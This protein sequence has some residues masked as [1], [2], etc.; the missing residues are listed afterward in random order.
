MRYEFS[1]IEKKW[2][3]RWEK[4]PFF[5]TKNDKS[6]KKF[7]C[8]DMFPYPSGSGLHVGHWK[9]YVFSDVYARIKLL[10]GY[11]VL[12]PM[13]WDAFG[14]PAENDAIKKG[15]H[16]RDGTSRN[17][18]VFKGQLK[19]IGATYDWDK[20]LSTIDPGYYKWTQWIFLKMYEAGLAYQEMMPVNWCPKCMTGL[21]NEE[22]SGGVCERCGAEVEQKPLRQWVLKITE[23]AEKLLNGLD[24]LDWPERVLL[25][26]K[27][28]IGKSYGAVVNFECEGTIL[29]IFTTRADTL[30]GATFVV[31]APDHDLVEKI[32]SEDQKI[33]VQDYQEKVSHMTDMDRVLDKDKTGVFT[34]SFA[35]NPV[36]GEKVSVYLASYVLSHYGTGIIMAVPAHDERDFEFAK[37]FDLEIRQ[38]V[39][40]EGDH[41]EYYDIDGSLKKAIV[42][43][44]TLV[45][46]GQFNGLCALPEGANAIIDFLC[47]QGKAKR[48]TCYKLRD[49]VFSRQRYW[50]EPIP[51]VHCD[52]CGV[53]PVPEKD[54]PVELPEVERYEPTGTGESPLAS[55]EEWVNTDCP[56]CGGEAK[57]ETNTMPQWAGSCW[58]F[59]RYPNPGLQDKPFDPEDMKYWLPVDLYVG[60]I[61]HAVLHLLY[62]RFYVK[63][64][65]NAGYLPF[66]EPFKKLF[67]QG[68]VC[69]RCPKSGRV[70]KMAKSKGN[71]VNP[72]EIVKQYGSD[73]LRLYMLFMGPPDMDNEWNSDSIK[74]VCNF[75][76]RL[77]GYF[78][79]DNLLSKGSVAENGVQKRFHRFLS[80]FQERIGTFHVNTAVSSIMEFL[81]DL[82]EKSMKLDFDLAQDFLA[83]ISI[84]VPHFASEILELKLGI[85]LADCS[86]PK[87]NPSLAS[88]NEVSVAVQ[89]N[90]KVRGT[91][92]VEKDAA[93]EIAQPIA[94]AQVEKWLQG[95]RVER[96]I[97]VPNRMVSFVVK[98]S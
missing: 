78:N 29:P 71:V 44:G 11:D 86:W 26:Q 13:G 38:V 69:M 85:Q 60:G 9:G 22:A 30:P 98:P 96:V 49:W 7:Y 70:E 80:D 16:P 58:Y 79:S 6:K 36:N 15:I 68:M 23:Y 64:L 72:D 5:R 12:H 54:L 34:G 42:E 90:G 67:N 8:L 37:K 43:N 24:G 33:A 55:V 10:E 88:V 82:N 45:N 14:L 61:E 74:G 2:Q 39:K 41:P 83:A 87:V 46:S 19:K 89:V 21:A 75:L 4:D 66:D 62:S 53:V 3:E 31:M 17:I 77:W 93:Q 65:H 28:W 56:K 50:G 25:M 63:F 32:T 91:I 51:L 81:N 94:E 95:M 18:A 40:P 59:L 35:T 47:E 97:F 84:M 76:G 52:S 20:E 73:T 1:A 92:V 27:N 48:K 57:R